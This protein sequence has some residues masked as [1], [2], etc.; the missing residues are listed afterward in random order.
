M[1][2][3]IKSLLPPLFLSLWHSRRSPWKGDFESW[4]SA[5][6]LTS[7]YDQASILEVVSDATLN[8]TEGRAAYERDSVNFD[9]ID[10]SWPVVSVLMWIAANRGNVKV[11][12]FGGS[13]GSSY[14]QNRKFLQGIRH[15]WVV[16]EQPH[17]VK[18]GRERFRTENLDFEESMQNALKKEE[19]NTFFSSSTLQYLEDPTAFMA[20]LPEL[21]F[22]FLIFDRVSIINANRNRL[23]IQTVPEEIYAGSMPCWFFSEDL[24]FAPLLDK[25]ELIEKF[26]CFIPNPVIFDSH[27][28]S[29]DFGYAFKRK[30]TN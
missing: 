6:R 28:R 22:E 23:T 29:M 7:G 8:V 9:Q 30:C 24:L 5:K 20:S 26:P 2:D 16:V 19:F 25:Y 17:F 11:V 1:K 14:H 10:Y 12:D 21:G 27:Q 18:R 13:L 4:D 3:L 15:K